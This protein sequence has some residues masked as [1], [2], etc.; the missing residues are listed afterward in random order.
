MVGCREDRANLEQAPQFKYFRILIIGRANAGKTTLL[1]HISNIKP[2]DGRGIHDINQSFYFPS[3]PRFV[4]HDSPGFEAGDE[5]QLKQ[6]Q[7]F[8][9]ERS[10]TRRLDKQLHSINDLDG[11]SLYMYRFCLVTNASRPLLELETRFFNEERPDNVPVIAIFTKF[12]DLISQIYDPELGWQENR[13][14]AEQTLD[15]KFK[16][17]LL[18]LKFPPNAKSFKASESIFNS[19]GDD[20]QAMVPGFNKQ[21][22][23]IVDLGLSNEIIIPVARWLNANKGRSSRLYQEVSFLTFKIKFKFMFK[24]REWGP[25][26]GPG[27][28]LPELE[29]EF[30]KE[31]PAGPNTMTLA[32]SMEH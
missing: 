20:F 11:C 6:V 15:T 4:F 29:K 19:N 8:I 1:K 21:E 13:Q 22:T 23:L 9:R 3:N 27:V 5:T 16:K 28:V 32:D 18:G 10:E 26:F 2:T 17:P 25:L 14:V 31:F 30:R 7:E 12:D 24:L